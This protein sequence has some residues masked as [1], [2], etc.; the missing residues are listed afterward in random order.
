MCPR[1]DLQVKINICEQNTWKAYLGPSIGMLT[2]WPYKSEMWSCVRVW[3][4]LL[5]I[6]LVFRL[7]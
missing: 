4:G 1:Y 7:G 2:G 6:L 5:I 3:D